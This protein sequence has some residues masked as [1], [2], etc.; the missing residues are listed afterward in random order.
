MNNITNSADRGKI[1][2][3]QVIEMAG[4]KDRLPDPETTDIKEIFKTMQEEN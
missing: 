4:L 3:A 1:A 2:M